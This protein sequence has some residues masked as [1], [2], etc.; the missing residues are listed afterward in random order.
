MHSQGT[1]R[2]TAFTPTQGQIC[3]RCCFVRQF[4]R[5]ADGGPPS[6]AV[7]FSAGTAAHCPGS[8]FR[9]ASC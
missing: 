7:V 8:S 6:P 1:M 9:G 2:Q 3:R 5:R 4:S